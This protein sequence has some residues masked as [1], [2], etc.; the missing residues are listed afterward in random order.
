MHVGMSFPV[1][2]YSWQS[3]EIFPLSEFLDL[4]SHV[5]GMRAFCLFRDEHNESDEHPSNHR[6][7]SP[8]FDKKGKH[9]DPDLVGSFEYMYSFAYSQHSREALNLG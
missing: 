8:Q 1:L 5:W 2:E 7:R 9:D 3:V 6:A 4:R